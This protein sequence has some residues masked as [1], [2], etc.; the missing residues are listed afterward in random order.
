MIKARRSNPR[1][2]T[3]STKNTPVNSRW[4]ALLVALPLVPFVLWTNPDPDLWG[5]L[6]FG[7]DML[8]DHRLPTA[9]PYSFTQDVPWVNHEWL[10]ELISAGAYR[11]AG[12]AGLIILKAALVTGIF[13]VIGTALD[14][15]ALPLKWMVIGFSALVILPLSVTIRPQLWTV[16]F[17]AIE[18]RMLTV[19][20][21]FWALPFLF[22]VWANLHG[23]WIV[24]AG[25]LVVHRAASIVYPQQQ[26][27]TIV[28]SVLLSAAATLL[29][30]YGTTLWRSLPE[31]AQGARDIIEWMPLWTASPLLWIEWLIGIG[32]V[33]TGLWRGTVSGPSAIAAS[34][35]AIGGLWL[36]R[37]TPLSVIANL[38]IAAPQLARWAPVPARDRY[39]SRWGLVA[40]WTMVVAT[41][42]LSLRPSAR[43]LTI[44]GHWAPDLTAAEVLKTNS[45]GKLVVP[46]RWGDYAIWRLAPNL[47]VSIDGRREVHSEQSTREAFAVETGAAVGLAALERW[48]PDYV[49][50]GAES[51]TTKTWLITHGYRIDF[52]G[53]RSYVAVRQDL[54]VLQGSSGVQHRCFP[55]P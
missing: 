40:V 24:G 26:R 7:L 19:G 15:V 10:H 35:L 16:L 39:A 47:K 4:L 43:C 23:A 32:L 31:A 28:L 22:A 54:P 38:V 36:V 9:D 49:W 12:V 25:V 13:A 6:R 5:H 30:P 44:E 34:V 46:L 55:G 1:R 33:G 8:R 20:C 11:I 3:E 52:D 18:C 14:E 37:L 41:L 48:R 17:L 53:P 45:G 21:R 51:M 2:P 50:L 29:T 42:A 27:R